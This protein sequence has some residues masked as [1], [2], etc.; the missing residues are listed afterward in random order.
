MRTLFRKM[1][2]TR[3]TQL[4]E[5][6]SDGSVA[7]APAMPS[8]ARQRLDL[9]NYQRQ[10]RRYASAVHS[11][12]DRQ[13]P[14]FEERVELTLVVGDQDGQDIVVERRWTSPRPYLVYR[15][16][17]PIVSWPQDSLLQP[18]ELEL[19]CHVHGQDVH[20]D[21]HPVLDVDNRLLVMILFQPGLHAETEWSLRY[22][23]PRLWS[24]LRSSG[25]DSFSWATATF[26]QRHPATTS[27]LSLK[28]IFPDRW[29]GQRL[30]ERSDFGTIRTERLP[31]GQA[32]FNWHH[33]PPH[34]GTYH[35]SLQGSRAP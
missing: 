33:D 2:V 17:G 26:D 5:L 19:V 1:G 29:T 9:E 20:V 16:V 13:Y 7:T 27:E 28:V 6:C 3:R 35:W 10:L 32:Q 34:A 11:L 21:I 31:T 12:V 14:L 4:A 25:E 22:Q 23:S 18:D 15:I 8:V 24:P 30:T